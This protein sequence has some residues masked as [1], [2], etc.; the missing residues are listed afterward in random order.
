MGTVLTGDAAAVK[1]AIQDL[2]DAYMDCLDDERF[3]A[4]PGVFRGERRL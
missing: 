3:E 1:S 4:W 2:F